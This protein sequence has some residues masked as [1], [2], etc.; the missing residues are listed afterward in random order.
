MSLRTRVRRINH[1]VS[2]SKT[3]TGMNCREKHALINVIEKRRMETKSYF[4]ALEDELC[5]KARHGLD[6]L[7]TYYHLIDALEARLY[8]WNGFISIVMATWFFMDL[9]VE[10][11]ARRWISRLS[12][13]ESPFFLL[14][15][16]PSLFYFL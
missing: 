14:V 10:L 13:P 3:K 5:L 2:M 4:E 11:G 8:G 12:V 16:N 15:K 9:V 6:L 7:E 1:L